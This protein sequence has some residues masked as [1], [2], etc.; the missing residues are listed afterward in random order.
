MFQG[1]EGFLHPVMNEG[2]KPFSLIYISF[3][4]YHMG[5]GFVHLYE[6]FFTCAYLFNVCFSNHD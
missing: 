4:L 1:A 5:I 2:A 3:L 6:C